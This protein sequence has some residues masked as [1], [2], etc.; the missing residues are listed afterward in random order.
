MTLAVHRHKRRQSQS[1]NSSS[2]KK[3][4]LGILSDSLRNDKPTQEP[5]SAQ[6]SRAPTVPSLSSLASPIDCDSDWDPGVV[7]DGLRIIINNDIDG[8]EAESDCEVVEVTGEDHD[9]ELHE[10]LCSFAKEQGDNPYDEDWIPKYWKKRA[11]QA[12]E[13]KSQYHLPPIDDT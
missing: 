4:C 1:N 12:C 2:S 7:F 11:R 6:R 9:E 3:P 8:G 10:Y 5:A 13:H